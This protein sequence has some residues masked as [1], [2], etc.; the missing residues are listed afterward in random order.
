MIQYLFIVPISRCCVTLNLRRSFDDLGEG[1]A[2]DRRDPTNGRQRHTPREKNKQTK[3]T[4][5]V[6]CPCES[7]RFPRMTVEET[8][9]ELG[10]PVCYSAQ[11]MMG[12]PGYIFF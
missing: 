6:L 8:K 5:F 1:T 3:K 7:G 10:V 11:L 9:F 2:G 12:N 4:T